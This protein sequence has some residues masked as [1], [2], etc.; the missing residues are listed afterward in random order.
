MW[1]KSVIGAY[2]FRLWGLFMPG[3]HSRGKWHVIN[4]GGRVALLS[5]IQHYT[6]ALYKRPDSSPSLPGRRM[7]F[8]ATSVD[9]SRRASQKMPSLFS[10]ATG[11][12]LPLT[13][14]PSLRKES[15][16][17]NGPSYVEPTRACSLCLPSSLD[18]RYW[19]RG[20]LWNLLTPGACDVS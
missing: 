9:L 7:E 13:L 17:H 12:K 4:L 3:T 18:T 19:G 11:G 2:R 8:P 20:N 6:R 10:M 5:F 1:G 14:V 16:A 15:R